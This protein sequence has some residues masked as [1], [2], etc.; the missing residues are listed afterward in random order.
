LGY[1]APGKAR[2]VQY[3]TEAFQSLILP[4]LQKDMIIALVTV[5]G[6]GILEFGDI[7]KAKDKAMTMLL[8]GAPGVGKTLTAV[9]ARSGFPSETT[10]DLWKKAWQKSLNNPYTL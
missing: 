2:P 10:T 8:H 4:E 6:K 9:K 1:F 5:H 7:I 3:N